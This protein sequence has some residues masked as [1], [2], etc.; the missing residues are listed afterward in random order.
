MDHAAIAQLSLFLA[1]VM[2]LFLAIL[3]GWK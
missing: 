1:I 2:V 3:E